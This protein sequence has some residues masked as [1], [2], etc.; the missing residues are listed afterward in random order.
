M[1]IIL[2]FWIWKNTIAD[3]LQDETFRQQDLQKE[4][5][6]ILYIVMHVSVTWRS[7][8]VRAPET[9]ENILKKLK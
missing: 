6:Q 4:R 1:E 2:N 7:T 9:R 8:T 5:T 3:V